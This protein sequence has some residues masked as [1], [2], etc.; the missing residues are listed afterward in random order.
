MDY[1]T[2]LDAATFNDAERLAWDNNHVHLTS[3]MRE[4]KR[5]YPEKFQ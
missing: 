1:A 3:K 5:K 4:H 2:K